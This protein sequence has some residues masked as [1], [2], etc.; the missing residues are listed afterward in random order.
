MS[1]ICTAV[2]AIGFR[3]LTPVMP[4]GCQAATPDV[5]VGCAPTSCALDLA[6]E[7][8]ETAAKNSP[9][10]G[11]GHSLSLIICCAQQGSTTH[12]INT[13]QRRIALTPASTQGTTYTLALPADPGVTVPGLWWMFALNSAGVPS[14]GFT[15]LVRN[16]K[17]KTS[18]SR[19][20]SCALE[21][22]LA[23]ALQPLVCR[24]WTAW[25]A[26]ADSA[27]LSVH[28]TCK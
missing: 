26:A 1:G 9:P 28:A 8:A 20:L 4:A 22:R 10:C 11:E 23:F 25:T 27:V 16:F 14:V 2:Y 15:V 21:D 7:G 19:A 24:V 5:A 6:L 18:L 12:C 3:A 17:P 13:D